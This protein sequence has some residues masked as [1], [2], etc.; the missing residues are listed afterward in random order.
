MG[1]ESNVGAEALCRYQ[2]GSKP[3]PLNSNG[4]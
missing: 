3:K 1:S 4:A 2:Q